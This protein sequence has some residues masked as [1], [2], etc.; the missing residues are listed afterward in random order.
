VRVRPVSQWYAAK[1]ADQDRQGRLVLFVLVGPA[2]LFALVAIAGTV[3]MAFSRRK[4]EI[5][6]M[7]LL[8]A[9]RGLIRRMVILEGLLVTCLAAGVATTFVTVGL[10]GYRAALRSSSLATA[11]GLPLPVLTGLALACIMVATLAGLLAVARALLRPAV[12]MVASR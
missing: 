2:S 10:T 8:G 11:G 5:A 6:V 3:V 4:R 12:T 1:A 7:T 9:S